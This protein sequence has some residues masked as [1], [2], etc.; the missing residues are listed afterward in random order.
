MQKIEEIETLDQETK[1]AYI[2]RMFNGISRRYD[3][4]NH[5]LSAGIDRHWRKQ[6]IEISNLSSG[7]MFLDVACGTGDLSIEAAKAKPAKIIAVD[8]AE[9]MLQGFGE[10]KRKSNLNGKVEMVQANAEKLP[11]SDNAFDAAS[12]AFG[13]RNFGD[14]K[15]GL[16]EMHRVLKRNGRIVVLEFSN[17]KHF[18]FKQIYSFYFKKIL[19][20]LGHLISGDSQAYSYLPESVLSFPDGKV[21]ENIL[22]DTKFHDVRSMPLTFGIAALYFGIK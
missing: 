7:E 20:A 21:F 2:R 10:K 12:V 5:F 3:F 15:S 19:P 17:P 9:K 22:L 13:V 8:F 4:L 11:F 14:L 1:N 18:P 16:A 6:A